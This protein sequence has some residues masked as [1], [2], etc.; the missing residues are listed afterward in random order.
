MKK[1][2]KKRIKTDEF[3]NLI[4]KLIELVKDN[5][6]E[7]LIG[8]AAFAF[9]AL[10][11]VGIRTV[12]GIQAGKQSELLG[13]ILVLEEELKTDPAKLGE[14]EQLGSKSLYGRL[15]FLKAATFNFESGDADR[16]IDALLQIP[17]TR[18]DLI[19]YQ[20]RDLLGQIYLDQKKYD[21]A[22]AIFEEL[23]RENPKDYAMDIV[24]F[25][26]AQV[27]GARNDIDLAIAAY[28]QLQEDFPGSYYSSQAP[29]EILKLEQKR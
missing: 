11:Y 5:K 3:V 13:Q 22:L 9:L 10:V 16:A 20:S 2:L 17:A 23:E 15:A 26:K 29:R 12:Q 7:L 25:R 27:L 24:L 8:A 28:T 19:Y 6:R 18:K 4:S 14:L 1:K 21:D